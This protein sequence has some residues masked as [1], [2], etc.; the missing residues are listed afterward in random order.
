MPLPL[1]DGGGGDSGAMD[2]G[3]DR[4]DTGP[5]DAYFDPD[6]A[7][8]AT[9]ATADI[10][11]LPV[12]IIWVI[13][14]SSSMS[15]EIEQVQTGLAN[16]VRVLEAGD[17]DYQLIVLSLRGRGETSVGGST[18]YQVCIP[19]PIGGADCADGPR[20]HQV[21]V[22]IRSTQP[23]EQVLGTLGQTMGYTAETAIGSE[24]WL[25]LLRP[26]ASRTFVFVS[27]D[28]SRTC[29]HPHSTGA[30][31]QAGDPP[32][33]ETSLFDFPGGGNPFNSNVLGPG[34]NDAMYG[35]TF[36]DTV[37]H[38]MYGWGSESDPNIA[39][40]MSSSPGWTYTALVARTSGARAQIC[41]GAS[42]WGAFFDAVATGVVRGSRIECE[43]ALPEP[44]MGTALD[45][46]RVNVE[47]RGEGG[48]TLVRRVPDMA[49]C[50]A[51]RGGWYYDDPTMPTEVRLCPASCDLARAEVVS[52]E[53]GLDVLFGCVSV[54]F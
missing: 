16:F 46:G 6:A 34:L 12:D 29:S 53:T 18:R 44:P 13:D 37:V 17:L 1:R 54:P 28:N 50:D 42:A 33:T 51:T 10:Q 35:D 39:C 20:F 26:G 31:C 48:S 45:P 11:R 8:S 3:P 43:I 15:D 22:D 27:D 2:A 52:P 7:C 32:L 25:P 9:S 49:G 23:V 14:N 36:R 4:P 19:P 38:A 5:P 40:D 47:I 24:P 41:D 21:E 30:S